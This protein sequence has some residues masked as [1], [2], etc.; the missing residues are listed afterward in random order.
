VVPRTDE[1]EQLPESEVL[2]AALAVAIDEARRAW[3]GLAVDEG[4]FASALLARVKTDEEAPATIAQLAVADIYFVLACAD[5]D[6]I[7]LEHFERRFVPALAA[8]LRSAGIDQA[9]ADETLQ[10]LRTMLFVAVPASAESAGAAP[11]V[12]GFA[13]RG[14]LR[15]WLQVIATRLAFRRARSQKRELQLDESLHE[16]DGDLEMSFL[17]KRYGA[18]F[19]A[20]FREAL[21]ELPVSDRLLLKQRFA[22]H[23]TVTELGGLHGVHASTI[24]RWVTDARARLV[25]GTR[26]SMMRHL[27]LRA[28]E[29]SSILRLIH[30][31]L[32]ISLSTYRDAKQA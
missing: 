9:A 7:A 1:S 6:R 14:Q 15:G 30:S 10:E 13:G 27:R 31:E 18:A 29:V 20:S 5:G 32:D 17:R 23:I 19:R 26:A 4:A 12:L 22:L 25:A 3:P 16:A 21:A 24:S 8:G 11:K 28:P 2:R